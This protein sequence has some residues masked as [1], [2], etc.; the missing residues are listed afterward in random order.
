MNQFISIVSRRL[1]SFSF[2]S[3]VI[4]II[5]A[6]VPMLTPVSLHAEAISYSRDNIT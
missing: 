5:F 4:E 6:L 1:A 2:L 3:D